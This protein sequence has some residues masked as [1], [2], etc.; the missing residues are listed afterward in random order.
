MSTSITGVGLKVNII[1]SVTFPTGFT[2]TEF[3]D[4][5]DPLDIPAIVVADSGMGLNGDL[6]T[7]AK[8]TVLKVSVAVIPNSLSDTSLQILLAANRVGKGK[9]SARDVITMTGTQAN[10]EVFQYIQGAIMEG[11]TASSVASSG[12]KK[13]KVYTFMFEN[14]T[15]INPPL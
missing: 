3:A 11:P 8:A 1:A 6:V 7:W 9:T 14:V 12:R 15:A 4:D 10:G 2:I 5:T 13:S